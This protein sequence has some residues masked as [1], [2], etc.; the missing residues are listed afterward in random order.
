MGIPGQEWGSLWGLPYVRDPKN[1]NKIVVGTDGLPLSTNVAKNFGS[2]TPD[3]VGGINNSFTYKHFNFSF[4]IDGKWGGKFFS[5]TAWHSYPTGTFTVTTANHVRENGLI[6][7]AVKQDGS[8]NDIRV[9]AQDYFGAANG[10]VWNNHEYSILNGTYVKLREVILGYDINVRNLHWIQKLNLS[11]FGRNLAILYRDQSTRLFGI[12][13]E[14]GMGGGEYGV[15][16]ENFQIPTTR[17]YG[18]KVSVKF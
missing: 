3:W 5:C 9:S 18:F 16:F 17:N 6:V 12:D 7:D 14:V 2:V 11:V 4:L 15:G 1:G 8:P 10:W 13:P